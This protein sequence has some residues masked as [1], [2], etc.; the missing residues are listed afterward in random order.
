MFRLRVCD[1]LRNGRRCCCWFIW[2]FFRLVEDCLL[3]EDDFR[4]TATARDA[5]SI[6]LTQRTDPL[7]A[8][9]SRSYFYTRKKQ[10]ETF[11]KWNAN[12]LWTIS[13]G[14]DFP[15]SR[16]RIEQHCEFRCVAGYINPIEDRSTDTNASDIEPIL[17]PTSRD[18][19]FLRATR[20]KEN[21]SKNRSTRTFHAG[22][23]STM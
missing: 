12:I 9:P 16:L 11:S 3:I 21:P 17:R 13:R 10:L 14:D 1:P 23:S 8:S 6:P 19:C 5:N 18:R 4:A 2:V 7:Q 20:N 15:V 22:R